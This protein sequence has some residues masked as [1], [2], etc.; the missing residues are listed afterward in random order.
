M[1]KKTKNDIVYKVLSLYLK[2]R[3]KNEVIDIKKAFVESKK[4]L[5]ILPT[6]REQFE[7][8]LAYLPKI[9]NI[10][11]NREIIYILPDSYQTLFNDKF[12]GNPFYFHE[13]DITYFSLPGKKIINLVKK[14]KF[15]ISICL[16]PEFSLFSAYTCLKSES[17]L[18]I[19]LYTEK[20]EE[21]FNFQVKNDGDKLLSER[22]NCLVKYLDMVLN[23]V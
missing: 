10:F 20:G 12:K 13:K 1:I 9:K 17:K 6:G 22:Y 11:L 3:R 19:G 23:S 21:Y 5:V 18:R 8:A 15:D 4:I 2:I 16:N 7:I 14:K